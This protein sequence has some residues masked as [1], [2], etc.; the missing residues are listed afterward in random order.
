MAQ[1]TTDSR[2][3]PLHIDAFWAKATITPPL[4]WEKWTQQWKLAFL[5]ID[6]IQLEIFLNGPPT[7]FTYPPKFFYEESVENHTQATEHDQKI[8][9]Q[10]LKVTWQNRCKKIDEIGIL[11]DDEPWEHCDQKAT[12]LLS[13]SLSVL[14][15]R[16][17]GFSRAKSRISSLK[18]SQ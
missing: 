9:N 5:A 18:N 4:S 1:S 11:C 6:G 16:V 14:G 7:G 13:L 3:T 8:R 2:K 17:V 15:Q 10:Q 12:S